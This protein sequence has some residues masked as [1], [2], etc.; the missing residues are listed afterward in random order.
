MDMDIKRVDTKSEYEALRALWCDTF[1]DGP[2]FVDAVYEKLGAEGWFIPGESGMD[3]ALTLYECGEYDGRKVFVSYA[4][5]T[6]PAARDRG[7][8][9]ELVKAVRDLVVSG[10]EK[11]G[12]ESNIVKAPGLSAVTPAE[13]SLYEFYEK[14]GYRKYF[15]EDRV[16]FSYDPD[17]LVM[18]GDGSDDYAPEILMEPVGAAEYNKLREYYLLGVPHIRVRDEIIELSAPDGLDGQ[19]IYKINHGAAI[20]ILS[21]SPAE[22]AGNRAGEIRFE[23]F[24]ADA[25]LDAGLGVAE[26]LSSRLMIR[27]SVSYSRP[28]TALHDIDCPGVTYPATM[29]AGNA[30]AYDEGFLPYY[31]FPME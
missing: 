16:S 18:D 10:P 23:E 2:E 25:N 20:C 11:S 27:G 6:A 13:E 31:G 14:L 19:N 9:G 30:D 24:I 15:Y 4:I 17:W 26:A 5:C 1:G 22:A 12:L 29:I 28:A 7:L 21:E 8:A 3:S